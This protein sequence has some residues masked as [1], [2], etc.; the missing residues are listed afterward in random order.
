MVSWSPYSTIFFSQFI[1]FL[2]YRSTKPS[3]VEKKKYCEFPFHKSLFACRST[4]SNQNISITE[5]KHNNY[6]LYSINKNI[7][8]A[9]K[10]G[11]MKMLFGELFFFSI[12]GDLLGIIG[13][14]NLGERLMD[15]AEVK[16]PVLAE[17]FRE[18]QW[19]IKDPRV[20][21]SGP[22]AYR[23]RQSRE[24]GKHE[25]QPLNIHKHSL[26]EPRL[27]TLRKK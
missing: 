16:M 20:T 15:F 8:R 26:N 3:D 21:L 25:P 4:K 2:P 12:P 9:A 22:L 23:C 11:L 5:N 24:A 6:W 19:I 17:I 27:R 18:N 7:H 13:W 10:F 1:C 14:V